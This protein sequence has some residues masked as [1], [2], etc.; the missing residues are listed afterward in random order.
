MVLNCQ[1]FFTFISAVLLQSA[2]SIK[3]LSGLNTIVFCNCDC[4]LR[5]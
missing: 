4:P 2:D 1:V 5:G 3:F